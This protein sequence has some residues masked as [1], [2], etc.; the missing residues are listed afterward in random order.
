MVVGQKR[1]GSEEVVVMSFGAGVKV[2]RFLSFTNFYSSSPCQLQL[3][4]FAFIN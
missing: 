1:D 2:K 4:S 3:E